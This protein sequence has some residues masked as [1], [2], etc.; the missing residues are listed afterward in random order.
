MD[1]QKIEQIE[2]EIKNL[3]LNNSDES[4]R[5][6]WS[7]HVK[8]VID[9]TKRMARKYGADLEIVWLSA[10]FHDLGQFEDLKTHEEISVKKAKKI[11]KEKGFSDDTVNK[12]CQTILTHRVNKYK[13]ETLEQKILATA[14]AM[15]HFKAPHYIWLSRAS[16]KSLEELFTKLDKKIER[17]YMEKIFFDAER[18]SIKKEYDILK[19]WFAFKL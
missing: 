2:E 7:I 6:F 9:E 15:S 10:I 11:L 3:H 1:K 18:E 16:K 19:D 17:D 12:V 4:V 8:T 14:D 5:S 13:P